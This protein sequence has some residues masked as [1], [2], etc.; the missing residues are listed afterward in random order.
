MTCVVELEKMT[1]LE[2]V[3]VLVSILRDG[4]TGHIAELGMRLG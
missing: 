2:M 1:E 4:I 3:Q